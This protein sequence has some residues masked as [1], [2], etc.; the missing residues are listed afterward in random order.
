[1]Q[2]TSIGGLIGI[3]REVSEA[4]WSKTKSLQRQ[5]NS[6]REKLFENYDEFAAKTIWRAWR[7]LE[8]LEFDLSLI[9]RRKF[10]LPTPYNPAQN[11]PTTTP[12]TENGELRNGALPET[13]H[14]ELHLT[15]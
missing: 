6:E 2:T 7:Q 12:G 11:I 15:M 5:L 4:A 9:A 1:M 13:A 10:T 14:L 3:L 8:R